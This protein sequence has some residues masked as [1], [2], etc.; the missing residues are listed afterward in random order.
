MIIALDDIFEIVINTRLFIFS[1]ILI[2][3]YI[4][5]CDYKRFDLENYVFIVLNVN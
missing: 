4:F 3:V 1:I 2:N 5:C